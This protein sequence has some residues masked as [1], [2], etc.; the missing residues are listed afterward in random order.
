MVFITSSGLTVNL[1]YCADELQKVTMKQENTYCLMQT[2]LTKS[3][4]TIPSIRNIKKIDN[5]CKDQKIQAKSQTKITETKV[6]EHGFFMKSITFIKSYFESI[7]AFN[8]SDKDEE[9]E[10]EVTLFPLLKKGLYIL[11]QQFRN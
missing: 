1:H 7:F 3:C 4:Q 5:C 2:P 6:K 11:L 10:K 9:K 8:S